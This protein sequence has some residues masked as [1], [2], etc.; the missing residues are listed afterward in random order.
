MNVHIYGYL[1]LK[2]PKSHGVHHDDPRYD[3]T[4]LDQQVS[5]WLHQHVEF[6]N[7]ESSAADIRFRP[8]ISSSP[9][10]QLLYPR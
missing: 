10:I 6:T 7:S 8:G 2:R 3:H 9:T 4:I 5:G 1:V